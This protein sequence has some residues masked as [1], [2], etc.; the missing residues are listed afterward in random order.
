[1][2]KDL[3]LFLYTLEEYKRFSTHLP[4]NTSTNMVEKFTESDYIGI[5]TRLMLLRKYYSTGKENV[6]FGHLIEECKS[7]FPDQVGIFEEL[8]QAFDSVINQQLQHILPDGTK[9]TLFAAIEDTV[10]GLYLHA[11]ENKIMRLANADPELRFSCVHKFVLELEDVVIKLGDILRKAGVTC[12]FPV[13]NSRSSVIFMGNPAENV[14]NIKASPYWSNVYG[15][16]ASDEELQTLIGQESDEDIQILN[17]CI[18]FLSEL[19]SIPLRRKALKQLTHPFTWSAWG[20]FLVAQKCF[21]QISNPGWSTKVRYREDKSVAYVRVFPHV[22][23][24]FCLDTPHLMNGVYEI[25]LVK[26][27]GEWRIYSFGGCFDSPP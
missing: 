18:Q 16:D 4:V 24:A 10:Y 5:Q 15:H 26:W 21:L 22:E 12:N 6:Y 1:M 13:D 19:S 9:Q 14:Q 20:D 2:R 23:E 8:F 11:D 7:E 3:Q 25:A 17:Y 27:C